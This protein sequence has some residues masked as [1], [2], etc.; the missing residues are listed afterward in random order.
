MGVDRYRDHTF[1]SMP[2]ITGELRALAEALK[3]S[4]YQ[5]PK[6]LEADELH[7]Q[8]IEEEIEQ[9]VRKAATGDHL[10]LVLSGHGFHSDGS[11]F[12]VTGPAQY[13][14]L[15][16]QNHCLR[17]EFGEFLLESK[18]TQLV[19]AVD[20]CREPF[21]ERS[22][23]LGSIAN[24]GKG[25]TGYED[26]DVSGQP[27]YAHVYACTRYETAGYGR[28]PDAPADDETR[29]FSYFTRALTEIA[30]DTSAPGTLDAM[31]TPLGER[32]RAIARDDGFHSD[33]RVQITYATGK[34]GLLL[35]PAHGAGRA[36]RQEGEH[37][38]QKAAVQHEA[39]H[40][41]RRGGLTEAQRDEAVGQVRDA[42]VALVGRWGQ[43]TDSAGAWLDDCGDIWR[44]AGCESRMASCVAA[45]LR[46]APDLSLTEAAL[47]VLGPYLYTA[48]GTQL[49]Y[50]ARD[51]R[52]WTLVDGPPA[53]Q[54]RA[55]GTR[56]AFERYFSGH[57]ALKDRERRA[58]QR[59][60]DGEARAVAWWLAR[61]WLLR[62]PAAREEVRR[63]GLAGLETL[64][65][66]AE[67]EPVLVR[68]VLGAGRLRKLVHLIGLDLE[69][70]R[71]PQS[72]TVAALQRTEHTVD[73]DRI[74]TLL[75]VAHHMAADPV[76]LP[77]LVAEHLGISEPV[78]GKEFRE[79]L[80]SLDWQPDGSRRVLS[81]ECPH[82]SVELALGQHIDA[83]DRTVRA[84]LA[85]PDG[86]RVAAWGVPAGF[87]SAKVTPALNDDETPRYEAVDVRFRL[88]GDRVRDLLM[89]EQLYRDRTLALRELYQN[90]LDACRYRQAR[91][92]LWNRRNPDEPADWQG[93][94]VFTQGVED[95]RPYIECHD[96]GVGMGRHELR[97][98]FAFAGS[99][100]VEERDFLAEW[101]EWEKEGITF[102]PNSRFG[103]G[104][105]S[106]FMLA[107]EIRVTTTRLGKNMQPG[108]QLVVHIDGP[109]ALFSIQS[110]RS[111]LRPGTKVRL[112]LRDPEEKISCGEVLRRQ[113]WVSDFS[114]RVAEDGKDPLVWEPRR[115]SDYVGSGFPDQYAGAWKSR[116]G[117][118]V[119]AQD[120]GDGVWW[121]PGLGAVL[122]DGLWAGQARFGAT[123][124]L[125][126]EQAPKLSVDRSTILD[127][128]EEYV[129]R[130]LAE[131]IPVLFEGDGRI[132]SLEWLQAL[133]I[134][135][136]PQRGGKLPDGKT[137]AGR[138]GELADRIA[139][140]SVTCGHEFSIQPFLGAALPVDTAVV[141]CS[142]ADRWLVGLARMAGGAMVITG[143]NTV[144]NE[145]RARAWSAA[146]PGAGVVLRRPPVRKARPTDEMI[147]GRV[148]DPD[149][150]LTPGELLAC[151]LGSGRTLAYV[152]ERLGDFGVQLPDQEILSRLAAVVDREK[153]MPL[154]QLVKMLSR[155]ADGVAPWLRPGDEVDFTRLSR[156]GFVLR[157]AAR[158]L[159]GLGF[160]VPGHEDIDRLTSSGTWPPQ[161]K[162]LPWMVLCR[163][164]DPRA[165]L[166][167]DQP[168]PRTHLAVAAGAFPGQSD[169][170]AEALTAAGHRLPR[171]AVPDRADP[172]DLALISERGNGRPPWRRDA[173]ALPLHHV[174]EISRQTGREVDDLAQRA[175][176]LG[177]ELS[178]VPRA[179]ERDLCAQLVE[180]MTKYAGL[181]DAVF[182]LPAGFVLD[183]AKHHSLPDQEIGRRLIDLGFNVCALDEH[184]SR[185]RDYGE[186]ILMSR[187]LRG[188]KPWLDM[189][190]PVP[191]YHVL[192]AAQDQL[193]ARKEV[194]DVLTRC[195]YDVVPEPPA[196]DW[197]SAEDA[198]LLRILRGGMNHWL[199][200]G[201]AVPLT[202]ILQAAHRL[203]RPPT[204][205]ARRL[206]QLG[207]VL[208]DD[209]EFVEPGMP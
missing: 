73:W 35:F 13:D 20:A 107:D 25:H 3:E 167:L 45:M 76:L 41:V 147:L 123:V 113:L 148:S 12:L 90:A 193:R 149:E 127:D 163:N 47:L 136:W 4:G 75:T 40:R 80:S 135:G 61:Q 109:G 83:L 104:V 26:R 79:T 84:V 160:Q 94:I 21:E 27:R 15:R 198:T 102:H 204:Q 100:F 189:A 165:E 67:F 55:F 22:K 19:V 64:P 112:Y 153:E 37:P 130:L 187:D 182:R 116:D 9:F 134:G 185:P 50:Q 38:W 150:A 60:R 124:N 68:Q 93:E 97:R 140:R 16:F 133:M 184:P 203:R 202:N 190:R 32:V 23:S 34:E 142:P 6:V 164:L 178:E 108:E 169:K 154:A 58:R 30:R 49:A 56:A 121:C 105:L 33:Q 114:V 101:A 53:D 199:R 62:L 191:W 92:E 170:I 168:V 95:G 14:S 65:S 137:P 173:G 103:V 119:P 145:W 126:G 138:Q 200:A 174:F 159:G 117:E 52:P 66:D 72:E 207:H 195:G 29:G 98:L 106:Y 122:A 28:E 146:D 188:E 129:G 111:V 166:P 99:R 171:G 131:K 197:T 143:D 43:E 69:Q 81:V 196:G 141:G 96:N 36:G 128:H 87:G 2:F 206:E 77:S 63:S 157:T 144:F 82:Q 5:E 86:A 59:G 44:P 48:F 186:L 11:D 74:G 78:N 71:P 85:R 115:L 91:T 88:D 1:R 155:D 39:W 180:D 192:W 89:G 7:A 46:S 177:Y 110:K 42:V 175:T 156:R 70:T 125:T 17:I 208:P 18:A 51:I 183:L 201:S 57:T 54:S 181:L 162:H 139:E 118:T 24:W 158:L 176:A 132:L 179:E 151:C 8:V 205:V 152:V 209:L 120:A 194:I 172:V 10:L 31:E 161:R